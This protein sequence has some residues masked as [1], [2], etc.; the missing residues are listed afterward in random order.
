MYIYTS[1]LLCATLCATLSHCAI[2]GPKLK[3][4]RA[5][6]EHSCYRPPRLKGLISVLCQYP[7]HTVRDPREKSLI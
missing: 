7:W 2:A 6:N 1:R 5:I 3:S 4:M